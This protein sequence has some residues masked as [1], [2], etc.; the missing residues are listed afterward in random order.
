MKKLTKHLCF[1]ELTNLENGSYSKPV[2]ILVVGTF[3][4]AKNKNEA[5]WFYGREINEFWFLFPR[6][7]GYPSIHPADIED[8]RE[9][10]IVCKEFCEQHQVLIIDMIK[11]VNAGLKG[12]T[13]NEINSVKFNDVLPFDFKSAFKNN[14]PEKV[15]F[16]WKGSSG[17][18]IGVLKKK[19]IDY[20]IENKIPYC[21]MPSASPIY[22]KGRKAKL[23]EWIETFKAINPSK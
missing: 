1:N 2:K 3:N 23:S 21:E 10:H 16:T 7:L 20:L 5:K 9:H 22:R 8:E 4:P 12:Y 13:D 14:K 11:Q 19:F 18:V 17:K 15:I 6:M